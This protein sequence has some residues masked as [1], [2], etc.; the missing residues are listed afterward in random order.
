MIIIIVTMS[1]DADENENDDIPYLLI[2]SICII[3]EI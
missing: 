3:V 1:D 2:Y